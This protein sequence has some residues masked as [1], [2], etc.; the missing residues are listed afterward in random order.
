MLIKKVVFD[1]PAFQIITEVQIEDC[2]S[3]S[4]EKSVTFDVFSNNIKKVLD[5]V[6]YKAVGE[7]LSL[8]ELPQDKDHS[9]RIGSHAAVFPNQFNFKNQKC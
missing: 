6:V 8:E 3:R 2:T 4:D 7:Q 1:I 5:E 9:L